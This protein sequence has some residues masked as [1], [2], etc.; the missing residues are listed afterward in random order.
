MPTPDLGENEADFHQQDMAF[1]GLWKG[2]SCIGKA[3][4]WKFHLI[5]NLL[6]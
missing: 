6:Y 2:E 1:L 4:R 5:F 3:E